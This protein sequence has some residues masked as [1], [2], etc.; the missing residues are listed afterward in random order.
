MQTLGLAS[1]A[2]AILAPILIVFPMALYEAD[3]QDTMGLIL[4]SP[5]VAVAAVVT[6]W[7]SG[8]H[9]GD[10]LTGRI[11]LVLGIIEVVFIGLIALFLFL[12]HDALNETL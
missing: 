5:F 7:P 8:R 6:G 3:G 10:P 4:L 11:G 1:L 2:C 12:M 9:A